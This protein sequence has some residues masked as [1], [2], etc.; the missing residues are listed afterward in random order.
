MSAALDHLLKAL[1]GPVATLA[2]GRSLLATLE[3]D[4]ARRL[5]ATLQILPQAP[6]RTGMEEMR[7]ASLRPGPLARLAASGESSS[8]LLT[9]A[10]AVLADA[11][12]DALRR[13]GP[14]AH[15]GPSF[16]GCLPGSVADWIPDRIVRAIR[17]MARAAARHL[18]DGA[19]DLA[20]PLSAHRRLAL[21]AL[22]RQGLDAIGQAV[23]MAGGAARVRLLVHHRAAAVVF[24]RLPVSGL[25]A[26]RA[27]PTGAGHG[28][29]A[30]LPGPS[31]VLAAVAE[32]AP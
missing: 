16:V 5:Q 29:A 4:G 11:D 21:G 22:P 7:T 24:Q 28:I 3:A 2:E 31:L 10:C 23:A 1:R 15:P 25:L 18:G 20:R 27:P 14:A 12:G 30:L 9:P 26:G 17:R 13:T 8:L 19:W 6:A 32:T